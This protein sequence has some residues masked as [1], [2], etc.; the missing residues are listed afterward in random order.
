MAM[1]R[2]A[3]VDTFCRDNLPP[4]DQ[5]PQMLTDLPELAYPDRLNCAAVLLDDVVARQGADR[6]CLRTPTQMW[7]Y[8]DLLTRAN[9]LAHVITED[10]GLVPG[11]RVLLRAPNNP[12]LVACWVGVVGKSRGNRTFRPGSTRNGSMNLE[13]RL[14]VIAG[15]PAPPPCSGRGRFG[16]PRSTPRM[17]RRAG[18][19]HDDRALTARPM[20]RT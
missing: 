6:P 15:I 13:T 11:G 12:W 5:W 16:R 17:L 18:F 2:S 20:R 9:Q 7:T 1:S 3:H 14:R 10:L 19:V 8:G 4:F